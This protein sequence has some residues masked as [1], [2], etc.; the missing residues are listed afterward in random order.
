MTA[1]C[2]CAGTFT[3]AQLR[4]YETISDESE[5]GQQTSSQH[6]EHGRCRLL[7]RP[8][9]LSPQA[10]T[11]AAISVGLMSAMIFLPLNSGLR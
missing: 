1:I 5:R 9:P 3:F 10:G 7:A 6:D 11:R 4:K 8:S 2:D